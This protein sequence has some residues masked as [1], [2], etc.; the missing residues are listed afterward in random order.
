ME[1]FSSGIMWFAALSDPAEKTWIET[2]TPTIY[3]IFI[4][5]SWWT[6]QRLGHKTKEVLSSNT[7]LGMF[8]IGFVTINFF[9]LSIDFHY[10]CTYIRAYFVFNV[11]SNYYTAGLL[12]PAIRYPITKLLYLHLHRSNSTA[13]LKYFCC[14]HVIPTQLLCWSTCVGTPR[15]QW[16]YFKGAAL[17]LLCRY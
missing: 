16:S 4:N 10:E 5:N 3:Q 6:D 14:F 17:L 1:M 11:Q 7:K 8:T 15:Y 12:W 2:G 9:Q 13:P